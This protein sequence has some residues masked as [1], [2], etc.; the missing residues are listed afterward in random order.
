MKSLNDIKDEIV[1]LQDQAEAIVNL[2]KAE[3]RELSAEENAE[4]DSVLNQIGDEDE[5][6]R[7]QVARLERLEAEKQRIALARSEAS[8]PV[9]AAKSF[10]IP[11][12]YVKLNAF[13]DEK[14]AYFAGQWLK[15]SFL[16]DDE[17]KRICNDYGQQILG[18]ATEGTD[19]AG[20]YLTPTPLSQAII[21]VLQ[22]A[23]V[24]RQVSNIV[25]MTSD[26]MTIPKATGG[27]TVQYPGEATAIT[28]SDRT[29]GVVSLTAVKRA[30]LSKISMELLADSVISVVDNL[31][32]DVGNALA[33][34]QDNEFINGDGTGSY[35]SET[36]V[37]SAL[38][39]A[40]KVTLSSGNTSFANV[41]LADLN[42]LVGLVPDKF[43]NN[44]S[45]I[46]GR[47]MWASYIQKLI[48]AAGG[49][50]VSNLEGG[51]RPQ[52]FGYPVYV[53]DQ[54]PADAADKAAAL[55]GNFSQG[56][57]IGDRQGVD[58]AM[59][60]SRYFDE[61]V[62]AVRS[63]VRYDINVH[64]AGDGSNAGAVVGLFTA[65]S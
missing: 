57:I 65:A 29:W 24:A 51:V 50:T 56:V 13:K 34:Q 48:Y 31:A 19:S 52:L 62:M 27:V 36:G 38:G 3:D 18:T 10:A 43:A 60:D 61:D 41:A 26:A 15:A 1:D 17:A 45:W 12:S 53:S 59:S 47:S 58:I 20:G 63:T 4:I 5:G 35:G 23:G 16:G 11:K 14:E 2:A 6:L 7:S 37:I 39:A 22:N 30:T 28:A 46:V 25:P 49:N 55:F 33:V 8:Q 9:Q 44:L 64:D 42:Q 21:D 40:G 54:M 32:S